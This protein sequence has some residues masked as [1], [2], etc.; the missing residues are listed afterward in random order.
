MRIVRQAMDIVFTI[1]Y[2]RYMIHTTYDHDLATLAQAIAHPVRVQL[3]RRLVRQG[4][5]PVGQLVEETG[6]AQSTVSQHLARLRRA[7]LLTQHTVGRAHVHAVDPPSL[8][9]LSTLVA[10]LAASLPRDSRGPA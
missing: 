2:R 9:R 10:G 1:G 7:G 6:L 4:P 3:L 5:A 8:R